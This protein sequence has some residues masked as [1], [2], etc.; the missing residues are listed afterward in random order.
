MA[1]SDLSTWLDEYARPG[2]VW[3]AKRLAAN[4]TLASNAHQAGP[5][6]PR[7]FLFAMFPSINRPG[8]E[9]PDAWFDLYVDSHASHRNVRAVWYNNR[10][11]DGT[12]NETRLTNFGGRDSPLLDPESTGALAVFVFVK[13][14]DLDAAECH[15]WLS[16]NA[17]EEDLVEDRIGPVEPGKLRIW[18]VEGGDQAE[19]FAAPAPERTACHLEPEEIPGEWLI[20]FPA[21]AEIVAK[22]M[23]FRPGHGVSSDLRL[24]RRRECE[25]EIFRSLE[26]AVELPV[27]RR[28]FGT[29]DDFLA[30]AQTILQRRKSRSGRS[31]ELHT[32]EIFMEDGLVENMHFSYQPV[33]EPGKSPDFL[34]PSGE[35]YRNAAFADEGLRMLAVKTT[36]KDRWRQILNEADRVQIKHLLTLQEGVSENQFREM[37]ESGVRL[38]VPATLHQ[39]YP[40]A[41]R[42]HLQTLAEFIGH[43]QQLAVSD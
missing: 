40:P 10:L 36:C 4:D 8:A 3:L 18:S 15:V 35:A 37:T 23:E 26:Q 9:N 32:R 14:P 13:H 42:P 24:I 21:G 28:G 16:R 5:Y 39:A 19:L 17:I 38:V 7:E 33:S 2:F 31:L 29:I 34:F 20:R 1:L 22:A 43:V 6:I 12:R 41:I 25:F 11:R 30:R 27:I